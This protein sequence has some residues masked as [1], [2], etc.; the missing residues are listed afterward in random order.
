[1]AATSLRSLKESRS[2]AKLPKG[3]ELV[4]KLDRDAARVLTADALAFIASLQ[5]AISSERLRLI[6]ARDNGDAPEFR[7]ETVAI[8]RAE[9]K[10]AALPRELADQRT[11]VV[12]PPSRRELLGALNSGARLC[13]A[14][15]HDMASPVWDNLIDG[16]INL[17]D[18]WTSAMEHVDK[19]TGR[20][21]SLSQKLA[22]LMVRVRPLLADE[23]RLKID[24]KAV[25]SGL[26]DAGLYLIHNARTA[27]AKASG[28]WLWLP[29]I[30]TQAEARLWNDILLHAQSL[31]EL[32]A[33]TI[34]VNLMLD[35]AAA[36]FA[37]DEI[38][39]ELREHLAGLAIGAERYAKSLMELN[40]QQKPKSVLGNAP[41]ALIGFIVGRAH[42]RGALALAPAIR[43]SGPARELSELAVREGADGILLSIPELA[44]AA[45]K[46][47]NDDM[48][49]PNQI[50]VT[51]D[52]L[53]TK[54]EELL[55]GEEAFGGE[56][57]F[58]QYAGASLLFLEAW[59]SGSAA[60]I[61]AAEFERMRMLLWQWT[62]L[63][64]KFEGAKAGEAMLE[65]AL[66]A[67]MKQEKD[68]RGE[69]NYRTGR[70]R[71]AAALLRALALS[72]DW[73]ADFMPLV[74]KKVE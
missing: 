55:A 14:D 50:Y 59:L 23:P 5:R 72:K 69:E 17:M 52:E 63:G 42:R 27:I 32:P 61:D 38:A 9:W 35:S 30:H 6:E 46:V 64:T 10:V 25:A 13:V 8:R 40:A 62:R 31:L 71:E 43:E 3:I 56:D 45:A 36:A 49:T 41:S 19:T 44:T 7:R 65:D 12:A 37:A 28:P 1:M 22:T 29:G 57:V 33:G 48:P 2:V 18:R 51:R 74:M 24:G 47:F 15:F 66:L 16:H 21:V 26:F 11:V 39:Y 34:R 54:P 70:F 67:A 20:R 60:L 53:K 73:I 68:S 58:R 4:P